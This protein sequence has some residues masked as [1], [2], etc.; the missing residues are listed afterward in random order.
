VAPIAC[1]ID[2]T[3]LCGPPINVMSVAAI[4]CVKR[5]RLKLPRETLK[6]GTCL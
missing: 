5:F 6:I 4:A 2:V 1:I 3:A